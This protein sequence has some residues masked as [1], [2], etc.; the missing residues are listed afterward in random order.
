[1]LFSIFHFIFAGR[2]GKARIP[3]LGGNLIV[4]RHDDG[5][6]RREEV[7]GIVFVDSSIPFTLFQGLLSA[8]W[9]RMAFP[10]S[11]KDHELVTSLFCSSRDMRYLETM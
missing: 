10:T 2:T 6:D 3:K 4:R 9:L 5:C 11:E 1:M 8:F 7:F